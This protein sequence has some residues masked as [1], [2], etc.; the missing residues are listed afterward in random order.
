MKHGSVTNMQTE[1][2]RPEHLRLHLFLSALTSITTGDPGPLKCCCTDSGLLWA[3]HSCTR[4]FNVDFDS[5]ISATGLDFVKFSYPRKEVWDFTLIIFCGLCVH[6]FFLS[7]CQI[8][9]LAWI[10]NRLV[11]I[12]CDGLSALTSLITTYW[13]LWW[14]DIKYEFSIFSVSSSLSFLWAG[15]R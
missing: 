12:S 13:E 11:G 3:F 5:D 2:V 7:M 4:V 10:S 6:F 9:D 14:T 15:H 8:G 1:K